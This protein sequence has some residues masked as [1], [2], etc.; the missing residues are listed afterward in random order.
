MFLIHWVIV[1]TNLG[2]FPA[3]VTFNQNKTYMKKPDIKMKVK[4]KRTIRFFH[5]RFKI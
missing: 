1:I 2:C 3:S 4:S 5:V